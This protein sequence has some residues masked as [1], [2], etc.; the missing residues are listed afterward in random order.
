MQTIQE[1]IKQLPQVYEPYN[2]SWLKFACAFIPYYTIDHMYSHSDNSLH[3]Y[4]IGL[5]PLL[6][7]FFNG[8]RMMP[9]MFYYAHNLYEIYSQKSA[10][11][12]PITL[13]DGLGNQIILQP[14]V[15]TTNFERYCIASTITG[16]M[17]IAANTA[18][19]L[20]TEGEGIDGSA[21]V[22][23]ITKMMKNNKTAVIALSVALPVMLFGMCYTAYYKTLDL[24]SS[25]TQPI[26]YAIVTP[27]NDESSTE[28]LLNTTIDEVA[29]VEL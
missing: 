5:M 17:R 12:Q 28:L 15:D 13:E 3:N 24:C 19:Y 18:S 1:Q 9:Y 20:I 29:P 26:Y 23:I 25:G 21:D 27:L 2:S 11:V 22:R 7:P 6:T 8:M 14:H 10:I 4:K 16:I